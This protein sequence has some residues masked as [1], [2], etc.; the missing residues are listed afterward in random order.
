LN[1]DE[2]LH[3]SISKDIKLPNAEVVNVNDYYT[4]LSERVDR[5]VLIEKLERLKKLKGILL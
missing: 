2:G 1:E 5:K 3:K 4:Q